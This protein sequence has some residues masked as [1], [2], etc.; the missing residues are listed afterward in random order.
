[1]HVFVCLSPDFASRKETWAEE[2]EWYFVKMPV[3]YIEI[4]ALFMIAAS[5]PPIKL[6]QMIVQYEQAIGGKEKL[7]FNRDSSGRTKLFWLLITAI[8]CNELEDEGER[9]EKLRLQTRNS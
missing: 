4:L 8:F 6:P 9:R 2:D 1:M 3:L 5:T 7:C